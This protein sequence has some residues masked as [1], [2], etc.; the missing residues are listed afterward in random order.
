MPGVNDLIT[1]LLDKGYDQAA[2]ATLQA[3]TESMTGGIVGQRLRELDAEAQRLAQDGK[4][5]EPDNPVLRALLADL[6]P[7]MRANSSRVNGAS[8]MVQQQ[9]ID[10]AG[11]L[12]RQLALPG[13]EDRQ[14]ASIGVNWNSPDPEAVNALVGYIDTP[15]WSQQ[16]SAYGEDVIDTIYNQAL[17]GVV[18][19]WSP[20]RTAREIRN[21]TQA[22][23]AAQANTLM[24]TL[25]LESYRSATAINQQANIDILDGQIRVGTLDGRICMACLAL[26]GSIVPA[27]ERIRDHHNGRCTAVSL[28]RGRPRDVQTGP[29]WF[30][31]LDERQQRDIA[32]HAN[33]EALQAGRVQMQDF[34]QSYDDPVFNEM[35]REASLRGILGDAAEEFYQR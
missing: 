14:L 8:P 5:L 15:A 33:Y 23:P 27:G 16:L 31:T 6:E 17:R 26:H 28:V 7:V 34:V 25:Q 21:M 3:I 29:A 24:R 10:A 19:G 20:L 4:K 12:T 9:A 30:A 35:L 11:Q 18:E 32:G 13:F 22:L 2:T 1:G